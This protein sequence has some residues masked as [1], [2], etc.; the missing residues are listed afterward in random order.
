[1]KAKKA[2]K[3]LN[4]SNFKENEDNMIKHSN[5]VMQFNDAEVKD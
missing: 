4:N 1:M 3:G 2:K 5:G